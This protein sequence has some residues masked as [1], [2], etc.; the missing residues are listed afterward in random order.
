MKIVGAGKQTIRRFA[1]NPWLFPLGAACAVSF[2]LGTRLLADN[3]IGFHLHGGR[4]ILENLAF[5]DRDTY[6][7]TVGDHQYV[8]L[9]WLFQVAVY[10]IYRLSSYSGLSVANAVLA[11]VLTLLLGLRMRLAG[12]GPAVAGW[13]LL[14]STVIMSLRYLMRPENVTYIYLALLCLALDRYLSRAAPPGQL[15][16]QGNDI[17]P[18]TGGA[19][20]LLWPVPLIHLLWVNTQGLFVL[21]LIVTGAYW[22]GISHRR[23]RPDRPLAG[24]LVF[25]AAV[26]LLNP[27]FFEG[28]LFPLRLLSRFNRSNVFAQHIEEFQPVWFFRAIIIEDRILYGFAAALL[29]AL[30]F[31]WRRRS[32]HEFLLPVI[33]FPLALTAV[34]NVP[35][36]I[37]VAAPILAAALTDAWR[38][39]GASL[40]GRWSGLPRRTCMLAPA[41]FGGVCLLLG[42]RIV[43]NAY[44]ANPGPGAGFRFGVGL[45]RSINPVAAG[46]FLVE[47]GLGGRLLNTSDIGGWLGWVLPQPVFIDGRLE[48]MQEALFQEEVDSWGAGGLAPLIEKYLPELVVFNYQGASRAW[49]P[50]LRGSPDWRLVYV[51]DVVAIYARRGYAPGVLAVDPELLPRAW[52]VDA[53]PDEARL[54]RVLERPVPGRVRRWLAGFTQRQV[55]EDA[56]TVLGHFCEMNGA[57]AAAELFYLASLERTPDLSYGT[58]SA[59]GLLYAATR[60]PA[61]AVLFFDQYLRYDPRNT[62]VLNEGG[63]AKTDAGDLEGAYRDFTRAIELDRHK[64]HLFFNRGFVRQQQGR[65]RD[66]EQDYSWALGIDPANPGARQG[67]EMIRQV[68]H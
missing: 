44:Y 3:N 27:Y 38:Q 47:H 52:G 64:A 17:A 33:L 31:T 22:L 25:S 28:F 4:W 6:T 21:G 37:V 55:P 23:R 36:F 58:F 54:R 51:D 60:R 34:R 68:G 66:A 63:I 30:V 39:L 16:A 13:V 42:A 40:G 9:H 18:A 65:L 48:V 19:L 61:L 11:A 62:D 29:V 45:D 12:A 10:G 56:C 67:L 8:D 41:L 43:T 32:L 15:A 26:C 24:V 49:L 53:A 2:A 20:R 57:Y 35:L 14:F 59:L 50:F 46:E 7:Y 5:P 1:R